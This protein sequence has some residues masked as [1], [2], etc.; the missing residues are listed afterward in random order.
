MVR[1][2]VR[3][4][5]ALA[6]TRVRVGVLHGLHSESRFRFDIW[7]K[8]RFVRWG[9]G[10]RVGVSKR[11]RALRGLRVVG[12]VA[13]GVKGGAVVDCIGEKL[14]DMSDMVCWER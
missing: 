5:V 9:S 13:G 14:E 3:E 1:L 6:P 4:G 8:P 11:R 12:G 7:S 2:A 10:V